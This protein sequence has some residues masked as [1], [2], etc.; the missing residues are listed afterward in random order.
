MSSR[1][2]ELPGS[3]IPKDVKNASLV[4]NRS[5]ERSRRSLFGSQWRKRCGSDEGAS[6]KYT[7]GLI[8]TT[9]GLNAGRRFR[10]RL[11]PLCVQVER[12]SL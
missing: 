4:F 12:T 7:H 3:G 11:P 1:Q 6:G 10:H 5:A 8:A 9:V 2:T